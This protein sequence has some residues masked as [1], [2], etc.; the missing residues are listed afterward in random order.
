MIIRSSLSLVMIV[1]FTQAPVFSDE[2]SLKPEYQVLVKSLVAAFSANDRDAISKLVKYPLG[3]EYPIPDVN[4][5]KEFL[6]RFD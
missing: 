5:E 4:N 1:L 3:R 6:Q 2:D